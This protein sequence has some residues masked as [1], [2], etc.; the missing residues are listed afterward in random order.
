MP[1]LTV[2]LSPSFEVLV[3][4]LDVTWPLYWLGTPIILVVTFSL[5]SLRPAYMKPSC[6]LGYMFCLT[7]FILFVIKFPKLLLLVFLFIIWILYWV[8]ALLYII[9][10]NTNPLNKNVFSETFAFQHILYYTRL[11]FLGSDVCPFYL[12]FCE[13]FRYILCPSALVLY[14]WQ[15]CKALQDLAFDVIFFRIF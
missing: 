15:C 5:L 8:N 13:E 3:W 4:A 12:P 6:I 1:C 9:S 7:L 2:F 14:L 10:N 11:L